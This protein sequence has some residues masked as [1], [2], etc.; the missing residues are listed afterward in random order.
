[1]TEKKSS[2]AKGYKVYSNWFLGTGKSFSM[3]LLLCHSLVPGISM[4]AGA[5]V[6]TIIR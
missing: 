1:M 3:L 4:A 5:F 2:L 6:V